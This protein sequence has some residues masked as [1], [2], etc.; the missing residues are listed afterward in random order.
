[1]LSTSPARTDG[2]SLLKEGSACKNSRAEVSSLLI[3]NK[4]NREQRI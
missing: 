3:K 4:Y 1:M 2:K